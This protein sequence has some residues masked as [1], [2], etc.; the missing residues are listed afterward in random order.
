MENEKYHIPVLLNEILQLFGA[1]GEGT[2]I[3]GTLGGGGHTA[4]LLE[5]N[6]NLR[7][8]GIDKDSDALEFASKRLSSFANRIV[9]RQ[10]GFDEMK[11][12]AAE[13][14]PEGVDGI[15][16]DL[17]V[18][19]S[20]ID[21]KARGF[22]F[23]NDGPLDMRMS[24]NS[25]ES[26][27]D[28]VNNRESA[29]MARVFREYGEENKA[30][31][32]AEAISV[33][34]AGKKIETTRELSEIIQSVCGWDIKAKARI[35]QAIRIEINRE[36]ESLDKVLETAPSLLRSGGKIAVISYHSL[37]DRRVKR[38]FRALT[39][40]VDRGTN[41]LPGENLPTPPPFRLVTKKAIVPSEAELAVNSRSRSAKM[42]VMERV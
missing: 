39:E 16:L 30:R 10:A 13:L 36:M 34:R 37:E 4:A 40:F 22:S 17:G 3:D 23:S 18:S 38:A 19:S 35:F 15:L 42:R 31:K 27:Y 6:K 29:D 24:A 8:I 20:Q 5:K 14:A 7:V 1:V 28:F 32:I 33:K 41:V 21:N 2:M 9:L 26:A 11:N 12:I 25:G